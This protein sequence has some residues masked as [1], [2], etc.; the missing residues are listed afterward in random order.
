MAAI[1]L[2][3][4][5]K[6]RGEFMEKMTHQYLAEKIHQHIVTRIPVDLPITHFIQAN[7]LPDN[8]HL[9]LTHP[10]FARWSAHYI[11]K[12]ISLLSRSTLIPG[13][14]PDHRFIIRLGRITHY[15]CDFFCAVHVDGRLASPGQHIRYEKQLGRAI[16]GDRNYFD[17]LCQFEV[18]YIRNLSANFAAIFQVG[19]ISYSTRTPDH[20]RD[21]Q[22]A[23]WFSAIVALSVLRSCLSH[24]TIAG[25]TATLMENLAA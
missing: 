20:G 10:H 2:I 19:Q 3:A 13:Q 23:V 11:Q 24:N 12:Q 18:P 1:S 15:L 8:N 6:I 17:S 14:V 7:I 16:A 4:D 5:N 9:S 21:I 22:L 25:Q